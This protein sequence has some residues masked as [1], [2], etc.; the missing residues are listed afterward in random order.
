MCCYGWSILKRSSA[1]EV[2]RAESSLR[3]RRTYYKYHT[4]MIYWALEYHTL[5]LFVLKE[6]YEIQV[7][8]FFS[9]VT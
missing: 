1:L 5:I 7:Y 4:L 2:L 9:L 8:T 6:P 3:D